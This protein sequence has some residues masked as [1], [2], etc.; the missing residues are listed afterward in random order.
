MQYRLQGK[1]LDLNDSAVI[2]HFDFFDPAEWLAV[3]SP[4]WSVA[5]EAIV[6]GPEPAT[7]GQIFYRRALTGDV[8]MAFTARLIAPSDHDLVWWYR[9][10]LDGQSWGRGYLGALGGWFR[11]R[12]GIETVP[13]FSLSATAAAFPV[14]GGAEYRI[15]AGCIGRHHFIAVDGAVVFELLLPEAMALPPD[16]AGHCGFGLYQSHVRYSELTLYRPVWTETTE[17]YQ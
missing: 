7:H 12:V 10:A 1:I 14:T 8:V 4:H 17:Y 15:V 9:V 13:D 3:G 2:R 5:P 16:H 6:G 11:N